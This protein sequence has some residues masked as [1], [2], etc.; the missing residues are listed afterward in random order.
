MLCCPAQV[1]HCGILWYT[2]THYWFSASFANIGAN[3]SLYQ[4]P[5]M[6]FLNQIQNHP[7]QF[8]QG[9]LAHEQPINATK[10]V[11]NQ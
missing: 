3:G 2:D 5:Q 8:H 9:H 4:H 6:H 10:Q 7:S 1:L 11:P